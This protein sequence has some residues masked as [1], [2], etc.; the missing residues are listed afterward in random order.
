MKIGVIGDSLMY[1]GT[2]SGTYLYFLFKHLL[3]NES[4]IIKTVFKLV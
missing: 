3:N 4:E 2:G 1:K